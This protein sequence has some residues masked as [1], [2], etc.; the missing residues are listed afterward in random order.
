[1][2]PFDGTILDCLTQ[3]QLTTLS[4]H[5]QLTTCGKGQVILL[6]GE[7]LSRFYVLVTGRA[8]AQYTF[9]R[10]RPVLELSVG[11]FFG[12]TALL[13]DTACDAFVRAAEDGTAV[14]GIELA[15]LRGLLGG[16]Q[17]LRERLLAE[18]AQRRAQLGC[19]V[20]GVS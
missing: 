2:A 15:A 9:K 18:V 1:M 16:C 19:A 10:G 12:E 11:D 17:P 8:T 20:V 6:R 13:E 14:L 7:V 5:L 4:P 3:E